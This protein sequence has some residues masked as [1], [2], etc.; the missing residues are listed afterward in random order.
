MA[1]CVEPFPHSARQ[2]AA[3]RWSSIDAR[4]ALAGD[5]VRVDL[6]ELERLA[7]SD[8]RRSLTAAA[9]LAR[10]PFL[11]GFNLRDSADFDDWRA[12]RAVAV[13]RTLMTV[14]D[15]L[16][17]RTRSPAIWP[18]RS[19]PRPVA[20]TSTRWTRPVTSG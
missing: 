11:A 12:G 7:P 18:V 10:G 15:R 20:W 6:S 1:P 3:I 5:G 17:V 4:V 2:S 14:L 16:A 8:S 19:G 9:E 13:E